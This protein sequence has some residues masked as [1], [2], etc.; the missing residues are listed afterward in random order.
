MRLHRAPDPAPARWRGSMW[1]PRAARCW[2][3]RA[4]AR[5]HRISF[6]PSCG[7]RSKAWWLRCVRESW[8]EVPF[9]PP[10]SFAS[11]RKAAWTGR[12]RRGGAPASAGFTGLIGRKT[13][14]RVVLS[15]SVH[16]RS[17]AGGRDLAATADDRSTPPARPMA[18]P[19]ASSCPG[20]RAM[21]RWKRGTSVEVL[22]PGP[23]HTRSTAPGLEE[24]AVV[25]WS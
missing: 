10:V 14:T 23:K 13:D 25:S 4:V 22:P 12:L 5:R 16:G 17:H 19:T 18:C 8:P 21:A 7:L 6:P 24:A 3:P 20:W 1:W 9:P 2:V 15:A 11:C